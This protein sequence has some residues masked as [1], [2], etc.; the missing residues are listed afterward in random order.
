M[1]PDDDKKNL[2]TFEGDKDKTLG[3]QMAFGIGTAGIRKSYLIEADGTTHRLSTRAGFPELI[4]ENKKTEQPGQSVFARGYVSRI[5]EITRSIR[6]PTGKTEKWLGVIWRVVGRWAKRL[7]GPL[8]GNYSVVNFWTTAT[9]EF[10]D[11]LMLAKD[12]NDYAV[13]GLYLNGR[14][15]AY[16]H[17]DEFSFDAMPFLL[18][19]V[20]WPVIGADDASDF[21]LFGISKYTVSHLSGRDISG[22]PATIYD[23]SELDAGMG[24]FPI[25]Y[26]PGV[27]INRANELAN[28]N[29]WNMSI[30]GSLRLRFRSV[31]LL[32]STPYQQSEGFV[33]EI[34]PNIGLMFP[35]GTPAHTTDTDWDHPIEPEDFAMFEQYAK[36]GTP[37][38]SGGFGTL[39]ADGFYEGDK[40]ELPAFNDQYIRHGTDSY[41][42]TLPL[43]FYGDELLTAAVIIE[44]VCDQIWREGHGS[45]GLATKDYIMAINENP[46]PPTSMFR[47]RSFDEGGPY[48]P[49]TVLGGAISS[50]AYNDQ[51]WSS[52]TT[53]KTVSDRF[54]ELYFAQVSMSGEYHALDTMNSHITGAWY[55][56]GSSVGLAG[57][58]TPNYLLHNAV[59]TLNQ[60]TG[61][62][63][64]P[65]RIQTHTSDIENPPYIYSLIA[66]TKDYI[67]FD[68]ENE[69]YIYIA[70]TF[71]GAKDDDF[72]M[73]AEIVILHGNNEYRKEVFRCS[74]AGIVVPAEVV[75]TMGTGTSSRYFVPVMPQRLFLPPFCTQGLCEYVAYSEVPDMT[76]GGT[77][78]LPGDM[79]AFIFSMPLSFAIEGDDNLDLPVSSFVFTMY[80]F[81]HVVG[82]YGGISAA[83]VLHNEFRQKTYFIHFADNRFV[84]WPTSVEPKATAYD[85]F[86]ECY[87]T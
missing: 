77:K 43:G 82:I 26:V 10:P 21:H 45:Y 56:V 5:M 29:H 71:I 8:R 35:D 51:T 28:F 60:Y 4:T 48:L 62:G 64:I 73:I 83:A 41:S 86:S 20:T 85:H 53:M 14:K 15:S 1:F 68:V 42:D 49:G 13:K 58:N 33:D 17:A 38:P 55:Y 32:R 70:G 39:I 22:H 81:L 80:N 34:H 12:G 67:L 44:V 78:Y 47:A 6:E 57:T 69:V 40:V 52:S 75:W 36:S 18:S 50:S 46:D 54:G 25:L 59:K 31:K 30:V 11:V 7:K 27:D 16:E 74:G 76:L 23:A 24:A 72:E 87:R 63:S 37:T 19:N 61:S 66:K 2:F 3:R 84:D 79:A 9:Q 65:T